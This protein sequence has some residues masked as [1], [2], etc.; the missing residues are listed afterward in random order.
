[1][2]R[3]VRSAL[4]VGTGCG[5][6]AL[7]AARHA[8]RVVGVDLNPRALVLGELGA[9]LNRVANVTWRAGSLFEP[10]RAERFDLIVANPP[11]VISPEEGSLYRDSPAPAD[12][13]S[14]RVVSE[15]GHLLEEG[16]FA[17][18]LCNWVRAAGEG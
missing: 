10:V 1:V 17:H 2:R 8:A 9:R 6:Q 4:D 18:I 13:I 14:Q 7:L 3:P 11:F 16:G 15:A 5:V 12:E